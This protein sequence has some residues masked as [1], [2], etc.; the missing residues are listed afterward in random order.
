MS[1]KRSL[2]VGLG[3]GIILGV[4]YAPH[5][6]SKTR[7][8]I[9]RTGNDVRNGWNSLKNRVSNKLDT[10]AESTEEY[11]EYPEQSIDTPYL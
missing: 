11:P 6:G 10:A 9:A 2:M 1:A 3:V 5:K 4:L 8:K 7:R